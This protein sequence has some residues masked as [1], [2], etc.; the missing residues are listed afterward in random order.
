MKRFTSIIRALLILASAAAIFLWPSAATAQLFGNSS[1]SDIQKRLDAA[2]DNPSVLCSSAVIYEPGVIRHLYTSRNFRPAWIDSQGPLPQADALLNAIRLADREGL[3]PQEYHLHALTALLS[4]WRSSRQKLQSFPKDKQIDCELLLTDALV[5][6]GSHLL[7]GRVEPE[8]IYP[9]WFAHLK[10]NHLLDII[11][12]ALNTGDID[13]AIQHIMPQDPLYRGLKQTLAAY[14]NI[15]K[16]GGWPMIPPPGNL[17]KQADHAHYLSLLR[18]RLLLTGELS[19]T[20]ASSHP[21]SYG[22]NIKSAV[23]RFQKRHALKTD[24]MINQATLK[25]MN[26]PVE[27]RIRQIALNLE[28]LRWL[29]ADIGRRHIFVNIADFEMAVLQ[30]DQVVMDMSIVVGKQK[31]RTSVFSG[32]MTHIELNPYWNIPK[33]I[34][35]KEILPSVQ[36]D[37]LYL[38]NKKIKVLEYRQNEEREI[39]PA[40]IDWSRINPKKL[41]YSFR[42]DLGP[43]NALGRI[44]FLFPNKFDIYLHDT[45]E[46]HLFHRTQRTFSHG[47][48]RISKPVDLA[49]Y[50]LKDDP[51]WNRKKILSEI[52]KGKRQVLK[53]KNPIDVHILYLTAWTDRQGDVQF[54]KD[55]YDGDPILFQAL[56][57]NPRLIAP[58]GVDRLLGKH[59]MTGRA[60]E[61]SDPGKNLRN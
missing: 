19:S 40:T 43:G 55:I 36:K 2:A 52:G 29:P 25:E 33:T 27:Q 30:D 28:R 46:R 3:K 21:V 49:E 42:Q 44:K 58:A 61:L 41:R 17:K 8:Q 24:G 16:T 18:Q 39:D 35:A 47:C 54:R 4:E 10:E 1:G 11:E 31:Q 14:T 23:L 12:N 20:E 56:S 13:A 7:N 53:L 59:A 50:L 6:Y 37:P 48:I 38:K 51:G 22:E 32:K 15:A 57:E 34:A 60:S 26:I 5:T 9:D 45:P